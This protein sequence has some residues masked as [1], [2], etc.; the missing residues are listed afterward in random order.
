MNIVI[1]CHPGFIMSQ[2]MP[3][4]AGFLFEGLKSRG[5]KVELLAPTPKMYNCIPFSP[6][7][8][9][10][11]YIDQYLIF[12]SDVRKRL[13]S[14][15]KETLFVFADNALGPWVPLVGD[16]PHVIHC[17]DFLAQQSALGQ[18]AQNRTNWTGRIYQSFIRRG[19]KNGKHFIS[20]SKKTQADLHSLLQGTPITSKVVYNGFNQQFDDVDLAK[21]RARLGHKFE[22]ELRNGYILHV[23]GNQ[24]YKNRIGVIALYNAWRS[25]TALTMPLLMIGAPPVKELIMASEQSPF[26]KDIH[27]LSGLDDHYVRLAYSGASL[28]LFPSLA[29]GFGWPIAEAMASGCVVLTTGRA[30][31]TEVGG[32]AAFYIEPDVH[33]SKDSSWSD[34]GSKVIEEILFLSRAEHEKIIQLGKINSARFDTSNAIRQIESIYTEVLE[35]YSP[36][37]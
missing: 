12:P 29:E 18:I 6:L 26:K 4:F 21:A 32:K 2:S 17:H 8:K 1:F 23:G 3:R 13:K 9:W 25:K 33:R 37:Q 7:K 22:L 20:V 15:S 34:E 19:Y 14:Y 31:M 30:P 11:G 28:F 5:H 27:F 36:K 24:W 16:R 10:M 35:T